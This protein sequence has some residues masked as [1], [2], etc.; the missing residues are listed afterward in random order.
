M[1]ARQSLVHLERV[2]DGVGEGGPAGAEAGDDVA[3]L[4]ASVGVVVGVGAAGIRR[5]SGDVAGGGVGLAFDQRAGAVEDGGV[6]DPVGLD[7]PGH[8]RGAFAGFT[9]QRV[10]GVKQLGAA[11][12]AGGGHLGGVV[13]D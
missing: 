13:V 8:R 7:L 4:L 2:V 1:H 3:G 12:V 6:V 9:A 10:V 11:A 5:G